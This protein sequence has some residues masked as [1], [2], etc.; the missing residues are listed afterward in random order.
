M[1]WVS[2]LPQF[3]DVREF[4]ITTTTFGMDTDVEDDDDDDDNPNAVMIKRKS[5]R[6]KCIPAYSAKYNIRYRG[7]WVSVKRI[8]EENHQGWGQEKATLYIQYVFL[9]LCGNNEQY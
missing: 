9:V 7:H 6:V 5:R 8:R 2:R 3:R 4:T 1:F